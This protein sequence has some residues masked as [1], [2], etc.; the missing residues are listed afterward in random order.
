MRLRFT[1]RF[2]RL[3][4]AEF[5]SGGFAFAAEALYNIV[6]N[7]RTDTCRIPVRTAADV[8]SERS[9]KK[10]EAKMPVRDGII[11]LRNGILEELGRTDPDGFT[12]NLNVLPPAYR[13]GQARHQGLRQDDLP[14]SKSWDSYIYVNSTNSNVL[15]ILQYLSSRYINLQRIRLE[16]ENGTHCSFALSLCIYD[17]GKPLGNVRRAV[18]YRNLLN[19]LNGQI[20]QGIRCPRRFWVDGEQVGH[21]VDLSIRKRADVDWTPE[22]DREAFIDAVTDGVAQLLPIVRR[23]VETRGDLFMPPPHR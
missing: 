3:K 18:L 2:R 16:G 11:E 22:N 5:R 1:A 15:L 12:R 21:V 4:T 10:R 17:L 9:Y 14:E 6:W 20:P 23:Y 8:A 13:N 19:R 7:A